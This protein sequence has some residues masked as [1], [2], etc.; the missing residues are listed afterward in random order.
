MRALGLELIED[1]NIVTYDGTAKSWNELSGL[2]PAFFN[3]VPETLVA[4]ETNP[5]DIL[6]LAILVNSSGE[7]WRKNLYGRFFNKGC[8]KIDGI[9]FSEIPAD[10][11]PM[12]YSQV[13][14][15]FV[16]TGDCFIKKNSGLIDFYMED[17]TVEAKIEG[18]VTVDGVH[19]SEGEDEKSIAIMS[20]LPEYQME[21]RYSWKFN[22]V[23]C[24]SDWSLYSPKD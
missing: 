4:Q 10:Q 1:Q 14:P 11:F 9:N 17:R 16:H 13:G 23:E 7:Y 6:D 24:R 15:K 20:L 18:A 21:V 12:K 2:N 19:I 8:T 22:G 5:E 3:P